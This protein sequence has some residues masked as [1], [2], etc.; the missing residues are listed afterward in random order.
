MRHQHLRDPFGVS[1]RLRAY[2]P[3]AGIARHAG[4]A[5]RTLA[6]MRYDVSVELDGSAR[7]IDREPL[8]GFVERTLAAEG[9]EE[10]TVST[11]VVQPVPAQGPPNTPR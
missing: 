8:I 6:R 7:A 4:A 2:R 3:G 11:P 1:L 5:R 9:V 10:G